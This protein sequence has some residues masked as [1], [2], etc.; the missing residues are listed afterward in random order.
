MRRRTF[1]RLLSIAVILLLTGSLSGCGQ[2][3]NMK[4][5][6]DDN[7]DVLNFTV[8]S[9]VDVAA[10]YPAGYDTAE[11]K[12][13]KLIE[14]NAGEERYQRLEAAYLAVLNHCLEETVGIA[15]YE[16]QLTDS[17]YTFYPPENNLYYRT[18]AFGRENLYLRNHAYIERLSADDLE[19]LEAAVENDSVRLSEELKAMV[20]NTWRELIP[21]YLEPA[22]HA[23]YE[24]NYE[25]DALNGFQA[26][27]DALTFVLGYCKEYD[28]AGNT[29][30][31]DAEVGKIALVKS[32][33]GQMET[34]LSEALGC[35]VKVFIIVGLHY[36]EN[37]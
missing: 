22:N 19:L 27:N 8:M 32:A 37:N 23:V 7:V 34:E 18:R 17:G 3:T 9:A 14:E 12:A 1:F 11:A 2:T 28:A 21:V 31:P 10:V 13:K 25:M 4:K 29:L 6:V 35:H 30:D 26:Y 16:K 24:I 33:A 15:R 5:D 36:V 20:Q